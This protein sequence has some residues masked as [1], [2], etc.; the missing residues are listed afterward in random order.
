[1]PGGQVGAPFVVFAIIFVLG[2]FL[3]TFE[4]IFIVILDHRIRVRLIMGV[5]PIWAGGDDR[6]R[7]LAVLRS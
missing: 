2:F 4:M 1:M 5:D 7:S 6:P 3:D